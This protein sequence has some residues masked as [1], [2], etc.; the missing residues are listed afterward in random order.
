MPSAP[1]RRRRRY[2]ESTA[3]V[4]MT[5]SDFD[6]MEK[7]YREQRIELQAMTLQLRKIGLTANELQQDVA[8]RK[9]NQTSLRN[10]LVREKAKSTQLQAESRTMAI[11]IARLKSEIMKLKR[12]N[13]M[14][15][16][17][18]QQKM[19]NMS[20]GLIEMVMAKYAQLLEA[21]RELKQQ[22]ETT[23]ADKVRLKEENIKLETDM[24]LLKDENITLGEKTKIM[25]QLNEKNIKLVE[26]NET[27]AAEKAQ[28]QRLHSKQGQY[29]KRL[30]QHVATLELNQHC[31]RVHPETFQAKIGKLTDTY[32]YKAGGAREGNPYKDLNQVYPVFLNV[33]TELEAGL[34]HCLMVSDDNNSDSIPSEQACNALTRVFNSDPAF[35]K[36]LGREAQDKMEKELTNIFRDGLE[37][38]G[39]GGMF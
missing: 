2:N 25:D 36:C 16:A 22:N 12:T 29:V 39:R 37:L 13:A 3:I 35:A 8:A 23:A 20:V 31:E 14:H 4:E 7:S 10:E 26:Q 15:V 19:N 32:L 30:E 18:Q 28:M 21:N 33:F 11:N 5:R 6:H 38:F 24:A 1:T 9:E 27:M 17:H 34:F